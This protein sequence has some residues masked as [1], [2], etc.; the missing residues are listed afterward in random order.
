MKDVL[1]E[2]IQ[3]FTGSAPEGWNDPVAAPEH[4]RPDWPAKGH[5]EE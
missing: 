3:D 4:E 5:F 1:D 2:F